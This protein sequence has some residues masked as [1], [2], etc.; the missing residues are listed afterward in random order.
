[1]CSTAVVRGLVGGTRGPVFDPFPRAWGLLFCQPVAGPVV[2]LVAGPIVRLV[3]GPARAGC[4]TRQG[5]LWGPLLGLV[6]GP[7]VRL[8]VGPARAGC[9][10]HCQGWLWDPPGLVMGP[11]HHPVGTHMSGQVYPHVGPILRSVGGT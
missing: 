7:V 11:V 3:A 8:V 9:G 4:G 6:A 10:V 5:L 2:R 1:V